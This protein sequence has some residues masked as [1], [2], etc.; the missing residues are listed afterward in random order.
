LKHFIRCTN[1][2]PTAPRK[3]LLYDGHGSHDTKEFK[4]L[5]AAN[6]IILYMFPPYLTYILQPLDVGCFQTYKHFHSL[7][8]HQAVRNM[9]LTY[10]YSCFL[11]DLPGIREKSLTKK[12]I[13]SAWAKA[14]IFPIDVDKVLKKMKQYSDLEPDDE[15][16]PHKAFF[17]TPKT[18]RHS[19]DLGAALAK[20]I[21]HKLSSPTRRHMESYRKGCEQILRVADIQQGDLH[22]I[23]TATKAALARKATN[24][25]YIVGKGPISAKAAIQ[26]VAEKEARKRPKK[27]LVVEVS[28]N[29][30]DDDEP[31]YEP[32]HPELVGWDNGRSSM[33]HVPDPFRE[34]QELITFN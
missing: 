31:V 12:T 17:S 29:D 2:G 22:T 28:D 32:L 4:E 26:A 33:L 11:Q 7:A 23:Q 15:L 27:K 3:L 21:E 5:A 18:I 30:E 8:V 6:N 34:Q 9:Q 13:V 20:K 24:R 1:S 19:L 10:D 25:N 16:P 14:G